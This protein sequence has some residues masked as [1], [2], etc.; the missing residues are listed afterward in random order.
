MESPENPGRF[1]L[2]LRRR[3]V[4]KG[5]VAQARNRRQ[6]TPAFDNQRYQT[7]FLERGLPLR[8]RPRVWSDIDHSFP[9]VTVHVDSDSTHFP[10]LRRGGP[11]STRPCH[12]QWPAERRS[13]RD[14]IIMD[15]WERC[16]PRFPWFPR[17]CC[18]RHAHT[19]QADGQTLL[20]SL[21]P[22]CPPESCRR[23]HAGPRST[24]R[25]SD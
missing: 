3:W 8:W 7:L 2:A 25:C 22:S 16:R 10:G 21:G 12:D 11:G 6:P 19:T 5:E 17:R 9:S 15:L 24:L 14:Y 1:N 4:A 23:C 20:A 18:P 13:A